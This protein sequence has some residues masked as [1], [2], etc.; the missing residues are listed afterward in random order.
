MKRD[1]VIVCGAGS[2][3]T[4][5]IE[6]LVK[7]RVPVVAIDLQEH[8]LESIAARFPDADFSLIAGDA[9]D[10]EV[11]ARAELP[12]ARGVVAALEN[13]KDNLYIVV[14]ARTSGSKARIVARTGELTHVEKLRRAGADA[15]ITPTYIGSMRL[16]SEL[17]RP[18][19][20][21]FMDDMLRDDRVY[22]MDEVTLTTGSQLVGR[23]LHDIFDHHGMNVLAVQHAGEVA[24]HYNPDPALALTAGTILIVLGSV[25]QVAKLRAV[26]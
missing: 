6:E 25:D 12:T 13:T 11:L 4:Y 8:E 7:A 1:H 5:I 18:S 19:I 22:R 10:D 16:V 2:T 21:R 26:A 15:I 17:L 14:A 9:T 20:V 3:G 24:W 23:P